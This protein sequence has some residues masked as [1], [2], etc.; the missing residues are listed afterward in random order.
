MIEVILATI[1][2]VT[3]VCGFLAGSASLIYQIGISR[4]THRIEYQPFPADPMTIL[5]E[6]E[7]D[8]A[9]TGASPDGV[10]D[11]NTIPEPKAE[12]YLNQKPKIIS[13]FDELYPDLSE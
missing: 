4:S 6:S 5:P 1:G 2:C 13:S 12:R 3:G 8:I 10:D 7:P 11:S 9:G